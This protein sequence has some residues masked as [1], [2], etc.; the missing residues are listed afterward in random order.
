MAYLHGM[1]ILEN[2]TSVPDPDA[3]Q[4]GLF[5]IFGTAPVNLAKNPEDVTNKLV[6]C[7][8]F[9]EAKKNFGYSDDFASYSLC[10]AMHTFFKV[11]G[12][13]GVVFCNVLDP[14]KHKETFS[15]SLKLASKQAKAEA[16]G[17]LLSSVTVTTKDGG[18][19][20]KD[21]DY[22]TE[23]DANGKLVVT[24][25][26]AGVTE[27]T[28]AGDKINASKVTAA[29]VIGEYDATTGKE[30]GVQLARRVYPKFGKA[31]SVIAAPGFSKIPEVALAMQ[32][33]AEEIN[34]CFK[35]EV[36]AD[37]DTNAVK[38]YTE[39]EKYKE[40]N[41]LSGNHLLLCWPMLKTSGKIVPASA[42]RAAEFAWRDAQ[43][44]GIPQLKVSNVDIKAQ[45]TVL[46]DGTEVLLDQE[47][48]NELNGIGVITFINLSGF[49]VWGNNTSAYP[50]TKDPKDRWIGCRRAFTWFG[51]SFATTY[52]EKV[53]DPANYRLVESIVDSENVRGNSLVAQGLFA[54]IRT[55]FQ[56]QDNSVA[57]II[58]GKIVFRQ[59]IAPYTPAE[60]ITDILEFDPSMIEAEFAQAGG[61]E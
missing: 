37:I 43:N 31:P 27:V 52:I 12:V 55:E 34:G 5:V 16:D 36:I 3:G 11:F 19:L 59:Y 29:D 39:V 54:G 60:F 15:E 47:Q 26:K 17:V 10:A 53:D 56:K 14:K 50:T 7:K 25:T 4:G 21:T 23:L 51:N 48:A 44:N 42:A 33:K 24:V 8:T 57:N 2:P 41:G 32:A 28:V 58:D 61:E 30:T 49:K 9:E 20:K 38:Q 13:G 45:A 1:Q 40:N 35:V 6:L 22:V 46:E 18:A